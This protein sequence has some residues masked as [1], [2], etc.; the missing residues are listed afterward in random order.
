MI[1][2]I[3]KRAMSLP[4]AIMK[5]PITDP[6]TTTRPIRA[7]IPG[8]PW[9]RVLGGGGSA[10]PSSI[11]RWPAGLESPGPRADPGGRAGCTVGRRRAVRDSSPAR[12]RRGLGGAHRPAWRR[13]AVVPPRAPMPGRRV[14]GR[15]DPPHHPSLP[16]G[17]K[18]FRPDRA[19]EPSGV[20]HGRGR[21]AHVGRGPAGARGLGNGSAAGARAA[22]RQAPAAPRKAA[23]IT[24][25]DG[26]AGPWRVRA[27]AAAPP[28]GA[29]AGR[30][31]AGRRCPRRGRPRRLPRGAAAR[32]P[33]GR[34]ARCSWT[35]GWSR[36]SSS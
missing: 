9:V 22:H 21:R 30:D 24:D 20:V 8:L 18:P 13:P 36:R 3:W 1:S 27:R 26:A 17:R 19:S 15:T 28:L 5:P 2:E 34:T 33:R 23:E 10:A 4:P 11:G 29:R 25:R 6:M 16:P 35:P 31:P 7:I 14:A 12:S 32:S